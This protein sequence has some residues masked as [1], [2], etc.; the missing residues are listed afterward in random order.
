[1]VV[2]FYFFVLDVVIVTGLWGFGDHDVG[3]VI[4]LFFTYL[5][6]FGRAFDLILQVLIPAVPTVSD[7]NKTDGNEDVHGAKVDDSG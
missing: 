3:A 6:E 2:L 1:M 7:V 5:P 4:F